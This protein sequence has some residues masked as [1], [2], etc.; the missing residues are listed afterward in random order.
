MRKGEA[1]ARKAVAAMPEVVNGRV[2][3]SQNL[4]IQKRYKESFDEIQSMMALCP[5]P[6]SVC[7]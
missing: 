6:Q 1:L 4:K 2:L 7:I 3:L 5:H